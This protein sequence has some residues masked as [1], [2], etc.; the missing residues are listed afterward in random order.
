VLQGCLCADAI[1]RWSAAVVNAIA[2]AELRLA[3]LGTSVSDNQI[4]TFHEIS[5]RGKHRF[6]LKLDTGLD[7]AA[8]SALVAELARA[9]WMP[10]ICSVLGPKTTMSASVVYSRPGADAQVRPE[11]SSCMFL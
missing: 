6:D 5:A 11:S 9:P 1:S 2:T 8:S 4:F 7:C 10:L 3:L